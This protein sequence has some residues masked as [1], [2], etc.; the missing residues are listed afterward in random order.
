M[1][2]FVS[3]LSYWYSSREIFTLVMLVFGLMVGSFSNV[4]IYRLPEIIYRPK[5]G[6]DKMS[7]SY[8][9]SRCPKCENQLKWYHN[10]PVISWLLLMG[11]CGF[12][13]VKIPS[14]YPKVEL[15]MGAGFAL[16]TYFL[17]PTYYQVALSSFLF[18]L[19]VIGSFIY[20]DQN[21]V[22]QRLI[23]LTFIVAF[24]IIII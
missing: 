2:V 15:L 23:Y 11:K 17:Y 13:E 3:N 8:P 12:C 22:P 9:P 21:K 24:F 4:V 19:M 6:I 1:D 5:A 10:V 18:S 7:L 16:V 20:H 14:R